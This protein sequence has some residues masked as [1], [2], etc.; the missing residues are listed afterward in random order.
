MAYISPGLPSVTMPLLQAHAIVLYP[1][2]SEQRWLE[3][4]LTSRL[5]YSCKP[6]SV[7]GLSSALLLTSSKLLQDQGMKMNEGDPSFSF[8]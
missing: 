6:S 3:P 1:R 4:R 7:N 2:R 8:V 5:V